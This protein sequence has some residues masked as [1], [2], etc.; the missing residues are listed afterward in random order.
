[1]T[2]PQDLSTTST[3]PQARPAEDR[4]GLGPAA[5]EAL[6]GPAYGA[7][8]AEEPINAGLH[9]RSDSRRRRVRSRQRAHLSRDELEA[10]PRRGPCS[11]EGAGFW[12]K[13]PHKEGEPL[14]R[15][16]TDEDQLCV[17]ARYRAPQRRPSHR[18][19]ANSSAPLTAGEGSAPQPMPQPPQPGL[20]RKRRWTRGRAP[21]SV[22]ASQ[23]G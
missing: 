19:G 2:I 9:M 13:S 17:R 1:V 6:A 4:R 21:C 7:Q 16:A 5:H 23:G 18:G 14:A 11:R 15:A 22:R 3:F 12:R 10:G 8:S 20:A